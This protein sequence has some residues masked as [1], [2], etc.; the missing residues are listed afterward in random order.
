[1]GVR[2]PLYPQENIMMHI[3]FTGTRDGMTIDQRLQL[4]IL[5]TGLAK[6]DKVTLHVGDCVGADET[7]AKLFHAKSL[8]PIIGHIPIKDDKRA[9]F[10]HYDEMMEPKNYMARNLTIV[11][12]STILL[13]TPKES[14]EQLRSGTWATIRKA[15]K[16]QKIVVIIYPNGDLMYNDEYHGNSYDV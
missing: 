1:M 2:L 13:A 4:N 11:L 15:R 3:G 6:Q 9:F 16:L 10:P 14:V 8:G 12:A 7:C 5:L